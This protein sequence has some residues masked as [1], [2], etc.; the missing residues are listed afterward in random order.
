VKVEYENPSA[1][2]P[3]SVYRWVLAG[4]RE[5]MW[6]ATRERGFCEGKAA[7]VRQKL[8]SY[9]WYCLE[10][11]DRQEVDGDPVDRYPAPRERP[12]EGGSKPVM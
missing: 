9:G 3:C 10:L 2:L 8:V 4:E 11:D 6:R 12:P 5:L 7:E 1:D